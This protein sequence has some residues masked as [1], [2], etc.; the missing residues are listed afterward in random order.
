MSRQ[1]FILGAVTGH[2]LLTGLH[3]VVHA[4]IPV[5]PKGGTAAFATVSLFLLPVG[6]AGLV[7]SGHQRI[8]GVALLIA[9]VASFGFE[10]AFHFLIS[11][12]D[13]IEHV[14][15]HQTSFGVTAI[16]TTMGNLLLV[17][18]GWVS[19]RDSPFTVSRNGGV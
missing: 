7:M 1:K 12:P 6:G 13:H 8:G 16:L 3:G 10:G 5:I 18:A 15:T 11:N 9:G 14:A 2:L 17:V 19:V 4:A